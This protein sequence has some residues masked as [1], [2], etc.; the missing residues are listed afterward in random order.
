MFRQCGLFKNLDGYYNFSG[1]LTGNMLYY[2]SKNIN[3]M[4]TYATINGY[5]LIYKEGV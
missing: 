1:Y 5:K 4:K 2:K 3:D